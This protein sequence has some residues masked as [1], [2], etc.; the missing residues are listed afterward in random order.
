MFFGA[1]QFIFNSLYQW[2]GIIVVVTHK[3]GKKQV[4]SLFICG[5]NTHD[6]IAFAGTPANF[7]SALLVVF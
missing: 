2:A 1:V 3:V 4:K 7:V 5:A 6:G